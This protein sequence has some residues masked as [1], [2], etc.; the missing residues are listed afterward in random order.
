MSLRVDIDDVSREV[1]VH[2]GGLDS[3]L[4]LTTT[5][6]LPF[7][8]I[9]SARVAPVAELTEGRGWRTGGTYW[10]G[11]VCAGR[12]GV[13]GRKGAR[14]LWLVFRDPEALVID[15]TMERPTRVVL[16]T[17]DR[18]ELARRVSAAVENPTHG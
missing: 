5:E 6:R 4:A 13:K 3:W 16:Q 11:R 2:L 7:E 10:P 15:T 8:V 14:Q 1:V 12:F 9:T 17:P 18:A